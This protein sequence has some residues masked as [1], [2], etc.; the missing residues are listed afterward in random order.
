MGGGGKPSAANFNT[1]GGGVLPEVHIRMH[2]Y[3]HTCSI[4]IHPCMHAHACMHVQRMQTYIL[5]PGK[6]MIKIKASDLYEKSA[7][8]MY[9]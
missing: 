3:A 9:K 4:F 6:K 7:T 5:H 8:N 2:M 1:G